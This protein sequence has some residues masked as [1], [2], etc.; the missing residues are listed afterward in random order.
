MLKLNG[1]KTEVLAISSKRR[2]HLFKDLKLEIG[3]S[4]ITPSPKAR[5]LGAIFDEHFTLECHVNKVCQSAYMHLNNIYNIKDS[6]TKEACE[7]I[8]H[9]FITS[10]LANLN[11]LLYGLPDGLLY[12][13]QKVQKCAARL[14][15]GTKRH[16]HITPVLKELHWLP[17]KKR[18]EFKVLVLT[19]K[20][21]NG[22][23]PQY[24]CD[25]IK[26]Y[27][28]TRSL[29][30]SSQLLLDVPKPDT[31]LGKHAFSY[32]GPFLW[33]SM[34]VELRRSQSLYVFKGHL[35]TYLFKKHF[36]C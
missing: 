33:N 34:P 6:I 5:N 2:S 12:K 35:K 27:S 9:A 26:A 21:M 20:C 14:L 10:R 24:L 30:S 3:N 36:K 11:C 7:S 25:K 16:E 17:V 4:S 19:Y 8:I 1:D 15:T 18:I 29:R 13:L 32:A 22:L 31:K 23:A 28:P